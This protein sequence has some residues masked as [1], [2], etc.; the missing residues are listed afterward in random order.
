MAEF[1]ARTV[2]HELDGLIPT[3]P[4]LVCGIA[5]AVDVRGSATSNRPWLPEDTTSEWNVVHTWAILLV[6]PGN[7]DSCTQRVFVLVADILE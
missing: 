4:V 2:F 3:P 1:C 6:P 5:I 7:D